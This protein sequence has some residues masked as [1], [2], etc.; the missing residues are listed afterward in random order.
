[1]R[2]SEQVRD[3]RIFILLYFAAY[4]LL[5]IV[6]DRKGAINYDE[7]IFICFCNLSDITI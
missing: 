6:R 1:M 2:K 5:T 7:K 4:K 3:L